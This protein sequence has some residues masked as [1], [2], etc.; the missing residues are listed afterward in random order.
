VTLESLRDGYRAAVFGASGGLGAAFVRALAA[1]PRCAVVHA[2]SRTPLSQLP[3]KAREFR[4]DLL[5]ESS[6]AAA[7]DL[8]NIDGKL[9]LVIVATG[10]LREGSLQPEKTWRS[11]SPDAFAKMFALNTTGPAL[12]AKHL[13]GRLPSGERA[14][15]AALSARVGSISDNRLGGWHAY[16]ASKA[17]LNMLMQNFAI[18]LARVNPTALCVALHPGTVDTSLSRPFQANVPPSKLFTADHSVADLLRVID[19]LE[20]TQSGKLMAWDGT[21]VPF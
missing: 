8:C 3:A 20:P 9:Q 5:A 6:I 10:V 4:F 16:R 12:I 1:D 7:A 13:L 18:E 14:V 11:V 15:F 21:V 2:G 17:A 19:R